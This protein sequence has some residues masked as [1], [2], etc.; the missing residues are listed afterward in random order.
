[1]LRLYFLLNKYETLPCALFDTQRKTYAS[2]SLV[3]YFEREMSEEDRDS[4]WPTS[5]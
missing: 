1:M 3:I 4:L 2:P 5:I